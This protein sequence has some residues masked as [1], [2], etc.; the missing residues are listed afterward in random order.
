MEN[1]YKNMVIATLVAIIVIM[2][3][4][5]GAFFETLTING[6]TLVDATWDVHIEKLDVLN[7]TKNGKSLSTSVSSPLYA[8]FKASLAGSGSSVTYQVTLKNSG[9]LNAELSGITFDTG[10]NDVIVYSYDG[11]KLSDKLSAGTSTNFT[12]TVKY[13]DSYT[14]SFDGMTSDLTMHLNYVQA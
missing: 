10:N 2:G 7:E 8:S 3:V 12:I 5:Y 4:G 6:T 1:K 13:N 11:I 9:T 14:G